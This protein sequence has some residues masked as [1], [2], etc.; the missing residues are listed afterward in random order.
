MVRHRRRAISDETPKAE[1]KPS[2]NK[3]TS[4]S[5]S[6]IGLYEGGNGSTAFN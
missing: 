3:V 5:P 1:T 4:L 2:Q 6:E